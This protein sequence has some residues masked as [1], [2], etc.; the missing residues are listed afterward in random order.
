MFLAALKD[1]GIQNTNAKNNRSKR[2]VTVLRRI[3]NNQKQPLMVAFFF[4]A[5]GRSLERSPHRPDSQ[6]KL[7]LRERKRDH[8]HLFKTSALHLVTYVNNN[9]N[10]RVHRLFNGGSAVAT[11]PAV[12]LF[13]LFFFFC[14]CVSLCQ[15]VVTTVLTRSRCTHSQKHNCLRCETHFSTLSCSNCAALVGISCHL[16]ALSIS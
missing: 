9:N 16:E 11:E 10:E 3:V 15:C 1:K 13:R 5:S 14:V 8:V 2:K 6:S 12:A 4:F 7:T